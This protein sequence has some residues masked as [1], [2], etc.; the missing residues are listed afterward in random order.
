MSRWL[1]SIVFLLA[2]L[3]LLGACIQVAPRSSVA[4]QP[5]AER[6]VRYAA[7]LAL[8]IKEDRRDEVSEAAVNGRLVLPHRPEIWGVPPSQRSVAPES[9]Q[10]ALLEP[11][12]FD[13]ARSPAECPGL[14][15]E[16]DVADACPGAGPALPAL[17]PAAIAPAA[18]PPLGTRA[19]DARLEVYRLQVEHESA[20]PEGALQSGPWS[21][22]G[23]ARLRRPS[24]IT[25]AGQAES[26]G[27]AASDRRL[28][29]KRAA[30]GPP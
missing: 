13:L 6:E 18:A 8:A 9:S 26:A 1:A 28:S 3:A 2:P 10:Q 7:E 12:I 11:G 20:P 21:V 17:S 24:P 23:S 25:M 22:V 4:F 27:L 30:T 5:P 14:W 16:R 29:R 19:G 15:A